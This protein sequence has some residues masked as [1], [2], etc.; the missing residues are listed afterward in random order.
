MRK[1]VVIGLVLVVVFGATFY[2][3]Y[4][5][6]RKTGYLGLTFSW[7][8]W[9]TNKRG[10][11]MYKVAITNGSTN[12]L[13]ADAG[14]DVLTRGGQAVY[15]AYPLPP[16]EGIVLYPR[17]GP[18]HGGT[19]VVGIGQKIYRSDWRG[20]L[21]FYLDS[22]VLKRPPFELAYPPDQEMKTSN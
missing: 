1:Y 17:V 3:V 6:P 4:V 12:T 20:R 13:W 10:E 18:Q 14:A 21:R 8:G 16:G 22:K 2:V 11:V 7:H 9:E 19:Q 5:P 15:G